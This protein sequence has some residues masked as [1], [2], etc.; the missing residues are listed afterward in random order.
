MAPRIAEANAEIWRPGCRTRWEDEQCSYGAPPRLDRI[1]PPALNLHPCCTNP[2]GRRQTAQGAWPT[3]PWSTTRP[4]F[5]PQRLGRSLL[6]DTINASH[7]APA[8][9]SHHNPS[10]RRISPSACSAHSQPAARPAGQQPVRHRAVSAH[11]RSLRPALPDLP[12]HRPL[13][14]PLCWS[15][16]RTYLEGADRGLDLRENQ[17]RWHRVPAPLPA[18]PLSAAEIDELAGC[19]PRL[20]T[21]NARLEL[22]AADALAIAAEPE[23]VDFVAGR[24]YT[25]RAGTGRLTIPLSATEVYLYLEGMTTALDLESEAASRRGSGRRRPERTRTAQPSRLA[26]RRLRALEHRRLFHRRNRPW[27]PG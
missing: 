19:L 14:L 27:P 18:A 20:E 17:A 10:H 9:A 24:A 23:P 25:V 15:D 12:T 22:A 3:P 26:H 16:A 1:S 8:H 5:E 7:N 13:T 11:P 21:L 6:F 4:L 2:D